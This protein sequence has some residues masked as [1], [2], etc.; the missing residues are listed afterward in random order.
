MAPLF[1]PSPA[2]SPGYHR[3]GALMPPPVL[4]IDALTGQQNVCV[5]KIS[6]AIGTEDAPRDNASLRSFIAS[7]QTTPNAVVRAAFFDLRSNRVT[8]QALDI[9]AA[10]NVEDDD[11]MM[12]LGKRFAFKILR[13]LYSMHVGDQVWKENPLAPENQQRCVMTAVYNL[14]A[15]QRSENADFI[16][17]ANKLAAEASKVVEAEAF[18]DTFPHFSSPGGPAHSKAARKAPP[19]ATKKSAPVATATRPPVDKSITCANCHGK[20]HTACT[21]DPKLKYAC[22]RCGGMGHNRKVC[23]S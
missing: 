10:G 21:P 2:F 17:I 22:N 3:P 9:I 18:L 14:S 13:S 16:A 20:G 6:A 15:P 1:V 19:P 7:A 11:E 8:E 5:A 4:A 23:P 12:L